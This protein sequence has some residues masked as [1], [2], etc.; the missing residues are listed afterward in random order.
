MADASAGPTRRR[1]R[2]A[3]RPYPPLRPTLA[4]GPFVPRSRVAR[5]LMLD[6]RVEFVAEQN[7]DRGH[8]HP[9]KIPMAAP[10]E[11]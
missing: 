2:F 11:P 4:E 6:L 8:P 1:F 7:D 9:D 3:D 5:G 10:S